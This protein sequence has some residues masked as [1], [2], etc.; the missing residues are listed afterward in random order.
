MYWTVAE[1]GVE[2]IEDGDVGEVSGFVE[3]ARLA[4][5]AEEKVRWL[6]CG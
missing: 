6:K 5:A 3:A 2:A 1:A 4:I